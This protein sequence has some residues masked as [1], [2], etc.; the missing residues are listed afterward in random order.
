MVNIYDLGMIRLLFGVSLVDGANVEPFD[1][2]SL[3][4]G[5]CVIVTRHASAFVG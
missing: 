3:D 5:I 2:V 1:S 4:D